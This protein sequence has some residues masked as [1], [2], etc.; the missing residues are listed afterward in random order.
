MQIKAI[1][2]RFSMSYNQEND[3]S[4]P[5]I[6][7]NAP[8]EDEEDRSV[9]I[10]IK[11]PNTTPLPPVDQDDS[12]SL[13]INKK[14]KLKLSADPEETLDKS[15]LIPTKSRSRNGSTSSKGTR[16][17]SLNDTY[18]PELSPPTTNQSYK[19]F[20]ES[21]DIVRSTSTPT[22]D[23]RSF[24]SPSKLP[25]QSTPNPDIKELKRKETNL[26]SR[27]RKERAKV[28]TLKRAKTILLKNDSQN[29]AELVLKWRD[30][31]QKASNYLYNAALEKVEKAGGKKEF[32]RR[33]KERLKD[34]MEYSM[35]SSF[36]DR[37]GE[38]TQSE[39]YEQLPEGEKERIL[40]QLDEEQEAAMKELEKSF[41]NE[42]DDAHED[43]EFSMRDLYKRLKMDYQLVFGNRDHERD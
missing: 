2:K 42:D 32:V 27:I 4:T 26:D 1:V 20:E 37:I 22:H 19:S 8:S 13:V 15:Q 28:E 40:Q 24:S 29:N 7:R 38:V 5:V 35:D 18:K 21:P 16:V 31:A 14:R 25:P 12:S 11:H 23:M 34:N 43:E 6:G 33:E 36:Q 41:I 3:P 17:P 30:A 9:L 39:E 10:P